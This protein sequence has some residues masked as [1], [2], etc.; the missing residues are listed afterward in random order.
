MIFV[1]YICML[2]CVTCFVCYLFVVLPYASLGLY[3]DYPTL[4]REFQGFR[5]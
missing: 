4:A 5:V 3:G 1:C 2:L